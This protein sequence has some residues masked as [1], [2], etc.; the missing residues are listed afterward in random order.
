MKDSDPE[1]WEINEASPTIAPLSASRGFPGT[2]AGKG[3]P[4]SPGAPRVKET[5]LGV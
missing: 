5:E 2:A 1:S 3:A 4:L